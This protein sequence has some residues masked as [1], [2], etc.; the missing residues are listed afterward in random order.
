MSGRV[1][2]LGGRAPVALDHARRF[3]R[4]GWHVQVADSIPC[5]LSGISSAVAQTHALRPP[6][7]DAR[8]FV[9]D[10]NRIVSDQRIDL[11]LPTC[12]EA[13]HL[14]RY[15]GALPRT[16][17]V[18]VDDFDT[19]A[20]LHSKWDFLG[21]ARQHGLPVPDSGRV[22][23]LAQA[24]EWAQ[25]RP[26]VLKP[27]FS[28]FGVHVRLYPD[29]IPPNAPELAALGTWV[30]Q[31]H[32]A[33]DELCSY[34]I[35]HR[36]RLLAHA[37]YRPTYRLRRSSSYYFA[38]VQRPAIRDAIAAFVHD[39]HYSGQISFDWIEAADGSAQAL[40]CNPRATSGLHL[41]PFDTDLPAALL[42]DGDLRE[43]ASPRARMIAVL[44]ATAGLQQAVMHRHTGTWQRDW[45]AA[46]DVMSVPG[47][48]LPPLGSLRDLASYAGLARQQ[49][50][51][52]REAATRDIE[53]DGE[54][55]PALDR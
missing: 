38:P 25:G 22:Q 53:W 2:I 27:E 16:L 31:A 7:F 12:E 33:G 29:G 24:R 36:G 30:V 44:M 35:A 37:I 48:R 5:R 18:A 41:F 6:R 15:R 42:G 47:D 10:L 26:V 4:L 9:S 8:G 49:R 13:L 1:L 17:Q 54:P 52:L 45:R 19:L 51:N 32:L 34:A 21:I 14:S 23:T 43:L 55:L 46:D 50:C 39:T 28:R 11:L 3:Q 40:E 20:A